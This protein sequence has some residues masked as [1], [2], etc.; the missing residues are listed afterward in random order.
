M[1]PEDI[2]RFEKFIAKLQGKEQQN[3]YQYMSLCPAHGDA[4]VSLWTKLNANGKIHVDCKAGCSPSSI[5]EAIGFKLSYLYGVPQI[6]ATFDYITTEGELLYQEVK[7]DKKSAYKPF[8][9]RRKNKKNE[10]VWDVKGIP[11]I[12]YNLHDV[13]HSGLDDIIFCCEGAKDAKNVARLGLIGTAVLGNEW[14][15][16]NTSPLDERKI[17]ILVDNDDGGM[18]IALECAHKLYGKSSSIKLLRIPGL[19]EKGDITDWL[20]ASKMNNKESLLSL[21]NDLKLHEWYPKDSI[22]ERIQNQEMTGL[23]FEVDRPGP[24]W[25]TWLDVFHPPENGPFWSYDLEWLKGNMKTLLYDETKPDVQLKT[26]LE[27]LKYSSDKNSKNP[28]DNRFKES[29]R[30]AEIALR[31]CQIARTIDINKNPEMPIFRHKFM[32][33]CEK[34]WKPED[35]AIMKSANFYIPEKR[36]FPRNMDACI[37]RHALPFDY[38]SSAKCPEIEKALIVQ[39][40]DDKESIDLLLEFMYY[41]MLQGHEYKSILSF[42]GV[43]N[44]GKSGILNLIMEF[45][46]IASCEAISLS[47]LGNQF[48]LFRTKFSK[49]LLCDDENVTKKDFAE[50]TLTENLLSIPSGRPIRIE[51]KGGIIETRILPG[52]IIIAGNQPLRMHANSS[53]LSERLKFLVFRHVYKRGADMNTKVMDTW[54]PELPGLMNLVLAAGENLKARGGFIEPRSSSDVREK[55]ES[56]ANPAVK[57]LREYM[58]QNRTGDAVLWIVTLEDMKI[59]YGQYCE[60]FELIKTKMSVQQFNEAMEAVP[61]IQRKTVRIKKKGDKSCIDKFTTVR[62]WSGCRRQGTQGVVGEGHT[63]TSEF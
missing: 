57:F 51:K 50:G 32:P 30:I 41:C 46:G 61:G 36:I 27:L 7:Y 45:I 39:W 43:P 22:R 20:N 4:N 26:M 2:E 44:T 34:N 54:R 23:F 24:I 5:C 18:T 25:E 56:G 58:E 8:G 33:E 1:Q 13:V 12:L 21:A 48:E 15:K 60:E 42:V 59:Y 62:C 37:A 6:V 63:D 14:I 3:D 49:L 19:P 29:P 55:F 9:V 31:Y 52:Q 38:D 35:I 16:T 47:K 53:G 28:N 11:R 40:G 17:I 10:W